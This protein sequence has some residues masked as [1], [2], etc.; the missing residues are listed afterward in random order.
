MKTLIPILLSLSLMS[1]CGPNGSETR[2]ALENVARAGGDKVVARVS[3]TELFAS[4]VDLAA[5]EQGLVDEGISLS[6]TDERYRR[7]LEELIDQRLLALDAE[8]QGLNADREAKIRLA[9]A[10]ESILDN[11]RVERH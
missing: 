11:I 3:G 4:D 8:S 7:V 10:R 9:V 6:T 5:Q 1:A 2:P